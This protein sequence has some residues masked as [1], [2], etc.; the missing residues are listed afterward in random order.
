MMGNVF[1]IFLIL[2]LK[3]L[4]I[5][6]SE[7]KHEWGGG[8]GWGGPDREADSPGAQQGHRPTQAKDRP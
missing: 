6:E 7:R 1:F 5:W 8:G 3:F 4:F 2:F